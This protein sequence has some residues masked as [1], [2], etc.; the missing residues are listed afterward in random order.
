MTF[1]SVPSFPAKLSIVVWSLEAARKV[2]VLVTHGG[3]DDGAGMR[4]DDGL[5][6]LVA[7]GGP[8]GFIE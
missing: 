7:E 1:I 2:T 5:L 8:I 6:G 4:H 3:V